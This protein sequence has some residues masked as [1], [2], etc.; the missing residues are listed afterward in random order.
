MSK[1]DLGREEKNIKVRCYELHSNILR[2]RQ[3]GSIELSQSR[4]GEGEIH[5][6]RG[7]MTQQVTRAL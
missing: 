5:L 3:A 4:D 7:A 1:S 2:V 6:E